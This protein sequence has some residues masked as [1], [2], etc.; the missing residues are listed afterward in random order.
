M[1][2]HTTVFNVADSFLEK[3]KE[4]DRQLDLLQLLKLCYLAHG[5][6]LAFYGK[7]LIEEEVQAWKYGP[8][9]PELYYALKHFKGGKLPHDCL[10]GL[11]R[12]DDHLS[13]DAE[14]VIGQVDDHY[15]SWEGV[16]LSTL[17]HQKGTPW[18]KVY[19]GGRYLPINNNIIE[20]HFASLIED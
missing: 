5:W 17:T 10:A 3:A 13:D 11:A 4:S 12:K 9:I 15:G 6:Y 2:T 8:V 16:E 18:T 19:K 20:K 7:P 1:A 14:N